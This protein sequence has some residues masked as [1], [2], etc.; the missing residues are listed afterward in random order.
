MSAL[1][2]RFCLET[3]V[4]LCLNIRACTL[5]RFSSSLTRGSIGNR[6]LRQP[7]LLGFKCS[8]VT[9]SEYLPPITLLLAGHKHMRAFAQLVS[10]HQRHAEDLKASCGG[11]TW[12]SITAKVSA[13]VGI[14]CHA[15]LLIQEGD[16]TVGMIWACYHV[17][18]ELIPLWDAMGFDHQELEGAVKVIQ[19]AS[20]DVE[21][22]KKTLSA[23]A[24]NSTEMH[25][26]V[27]LTAEWNHQP[28]K[29]VQTMFSIGSES[30]PT[31]S[32]V[33][34]RSLPWLDALRNCDLF[35]IL[36]TRLEHIQSL[37][38][39]VLAAA[40]QWGRMLTQFNEQTITFSDLEAYAQPLLEPGALRAFACT[41]E[42]A[43]QDP[44]SF[45]VDFNPGRK[46]IRVTSE[47]LEAFQ[48]IQRIQH[49]KQDIKD[50]LQVVGNWVSPCGSQTVEDAKVALEKVAAEI[51]SF[52]W[53]QL[54][55]SD[56]PRF[57]FASLLERWG[58]PSD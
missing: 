25:T 31:F 50:I 40:S 37:D 42:G 33:L 16:A 43:D 3:L 45:S 1:S 27:T 22:A 53:D 57:E 32:E 8:Q 28:L 35:H 38:D 7:A 15:L 49:N 5:M 52:E 56:L 58:S 48:H 41:A 11:G 54:T 20:I 55:L 10:W 23:Y 4:A 18:G 19:T 44:P 51:E 29:G 26:L 36:W 24:M 6:S 9:T 12:N 34:V 21:S 17:R 30:E 39:R 14:V 13:L 2:L 47:S 46:W